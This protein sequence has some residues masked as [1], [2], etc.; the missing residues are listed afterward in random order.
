MIKSV[1]VEFIAAHAQ[2]HAEI[3]A[4]GFADGLQ[5]IQPK[6]QTIA[7]AAAIGVVAEVGA[8]APELI[9]QMLVRGRYL[10]AVHARLLHPLGGRGEVAD[11]APDFF[12]FDGLGVAPVHGLAHAG[13]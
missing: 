1:V 13:R 4:H 8:R 10:D 12:H 5:H 9:D 11:D 6:A 3:R 2:A 7:Q